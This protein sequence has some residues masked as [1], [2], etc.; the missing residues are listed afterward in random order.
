[1]KLILDSDPRVNLVRRYEPGAIQVG[2]QVLRAPFIL[3][4]D[5]LE[6]LWPVQ[7]LGQLSEADLAPLLALQ[8]QIVL[9]GGA[10][11]DPGRV[12]PLRRQLGQRGV[13]LEVMELGAACRTYNIL[14]QEA[15][16]VV[17]GLFP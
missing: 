5:R 4:A 14:A 2:E 8:P 16:R 6:P 10:A 9:L 17:A 3:S 11:A 13:A 12:L 7:S 1:M 15:R